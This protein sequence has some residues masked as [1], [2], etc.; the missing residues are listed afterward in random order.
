[1]NINVLN[2]YVLNDD[3]YAHYYESIIILLYEKKVNWIFIRQFFFFMDKQ[4]LYKTILIMLLLSFY[5]F[6]I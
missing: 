3:H 6:I 4:F 5:I 2:I 1:M